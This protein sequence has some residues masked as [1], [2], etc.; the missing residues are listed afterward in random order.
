MGEMTARQLLGKGVG[1]AH[2][3]EPDVRARGR[4]R[5]RARRH[6]PSRSSV[7]S[8]MLPLA[9]LVVVRGRRRRPARGPAQVEEAMRERR[10]RP[11]LL[12]D[13][14]VPRCHRA[15]GE[16]P[17]RRLPLRHRRP[18]RRGGGEPRGA[19]AVEAVR[20][21][22]IVDDEVDAFWRWLE[23]LDVV[24]TIVALRDKV[25]RHP[26]ARG[27]APS[28]GAGCPRAAPARGDRA[29]HPRD[30][31]QGPARSGDRAAAAP[32]GATARASTSRRRA[33]CSGSSGDDPG[34]EEE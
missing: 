10:G 6:A 34:D 23:G 16:R 13:L 29:P 25:E 32:G 15:G 5:R 1:H 27:G 9:D 14:A 20:A 2:G 31:Q 21:E 3:G 30:R 22:A 12:I 4:R 18:R 33:R 28:L 11:M 8:R 19:R 26:A 24:P 7:S 17:R